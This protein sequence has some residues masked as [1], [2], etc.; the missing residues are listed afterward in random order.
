MP[1][2]LT[3]KLYDAPII[4]YNFLS[5]NLAL[6]KKVFLKQVGSRLSRSLNEW[7]T[8]LSGE[9]IATNSF[10]DDPINK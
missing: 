4:T 7:F 8:R 1:Q 2:I 6:D 9:N 5:S 10:Q 3:L